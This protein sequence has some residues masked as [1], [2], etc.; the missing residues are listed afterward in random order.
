MAGKPAQRGGDPPVASQLLPSTL[1][2]TSEGFQDALTL[3]LFGGGMLPPSLPS[4]MGAE[5]K[6]AAK[7][8]AKRMRKG[9]PPKFAYL[10]PQGALCCAALWCAVLCCGGTWCTRHPATR[11]PLTPVLLPPFLPFL[12]QASSA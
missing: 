1:G 10:D 4:E 7:A 12:L 11:H 6:A 5:A 8:A 3:A 9:L 2:V